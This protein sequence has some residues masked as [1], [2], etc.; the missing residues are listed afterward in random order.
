VFEWK[1]TANRGVRIN[2]NTNSSVLGCNVMSSHTWLPVF[3]GNM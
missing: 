2:E 3:L 1:E